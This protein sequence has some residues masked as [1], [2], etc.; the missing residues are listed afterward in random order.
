MNLGKTLESVDKFYVVLAIVL[1]LMA[2]LVIFSFRGIFNALLSAY[3]ID[4]GSISVDSTVEKQN[5]NEAYNWV[6][7]RGSIRLEITD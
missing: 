3:E 4:Q 1:V 5:L 6:Y 7:N 2:I